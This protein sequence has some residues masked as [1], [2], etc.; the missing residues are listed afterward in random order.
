MG[1]IPE[2]FTH[3]ESHK[4]EITKHINSMFLKSQDEENTKKNTEEGSQ[5]NEEEEHKEMGE[6]TKKAIKNFIKTHPYL[7]DE[8]FHSFAEKMGIDKHE[9][10]EVV[11]QLLNEIYSDDNLNKL[12]G[13]K[14]EGMTAQD[15][16]NK[17]NIPL[18]EL[19]KQIN[20]GVK[21][22]REHTNNEQ[23]ALE[24]T[25]DHLFEDA[26]YY[27]DPKP[28]DWAEKEIKKEEEVTEKSIDDLLL[29]KAL[30]PREGEIREYKDGRY[31]FEGGHW[32]KIK[33]IDK[34]EKLSEG[35]LV[36]YTNIY[37]I[38]F[39]GK[40]IEIDK[41]K[42]YAKVKNSIGNIDYQPIGDFKK[43]IKLD[44]KKNVE[45]DYEAYE[46]YKDGIGFYIYHPDSNFYLKINN[47]NVIKG[48]LE[49][50][51]AAA[52]DFLKNK[53]KK[54]TLIEEKIKEKEEKNATAAYNWL[55]EHNMTATS[56]ELNQ[57]AESAVKSGI[58]TPKERELIKKK[59]EEKSKEDV[60][61]IIS[62]LKEDEFITQIGKE[63][64]W[65]AILTKE[66]KN[67]ILGLE[68]M[69]TYKFKDEQGMEWE[70]ENID[71]D[72]YHIKGLNSRNDTYKGNFELKK[73]SIKPVA[74]VI[75]EDGNV[76]NL[77]GICMKALKRAGQSE[78]AKEMQERIF[79]AGSYDEALSIMGEYCDLQ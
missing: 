30:P 62:V 18:Q 42:K 67:K 27:T 59:F 5:E 68:N 7:D 48:T 64:Y 53:G 38:S 77:I 33:D 9:A 73:E 40:I 76:F 79:K 10:E 32:K 24:I 56:Y 14:A 21:I 58:L 8:E 66:D 35:D 41:D 50:C 49:I 4:N 65:S 1:K 69:E 46:A 60:I 25:L 19:Q 51:K 16:V 47:K 13:G 28:K 36:T 52:I 43:N 61:P 37:G 72:F 44:W 23:K 63:G 74:K 31:K 26:K 11:Y 29:T 55:K 20:I 75:G 12:K 22:E 54:S 45:G 78:K 3:I 6:N 70:V 34:T 15:I 17:H 71:K 57:A 39:N 2:D